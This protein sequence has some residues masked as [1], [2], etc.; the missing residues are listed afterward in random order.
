M[1]QT[2]IASPVFWGPPGATAT[3]ASLVLWGVGTT[4]AFRAHWMLAEMRLPYISHR[5]Q[6]RTGETMTAEYLK[7]N[8]RHKIPTLQHGT[9]CMGES[10]AIVQY[11]CE[12]FQTPA[13]FYAPTDPAARAKINEWCYFVMNELDGHTLYVI[14]RHVGLKHIY[15]E[16]P[17]A[18]ASAK[19]YFREQIQALESKFPTAGNYLFGEHLSIADMLLATCLDWA[20]GVDIPLPDPVMAYRERVNRRPAYGVACYRNDPA[21]V[22][23]PEAVLCAVTTRNS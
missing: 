2:A 16:A 4:R 14:R 3:D 12:R 13:D 22:P 15:G 1:S 8:P 18:V 6:S 17:E 11:L 21:T 19:I 23:P 5:I 10:A 9:L 7:L 20:V